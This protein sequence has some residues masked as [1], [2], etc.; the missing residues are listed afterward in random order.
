MFLRAGSHPERTTLPWDSCSIPPLS[1]SH[2][3][4]DDDHP[5]V[6]RT[7]GVVTAGR[8]QVKFVYAISESPGIDRDGGGPEGLRAVRTSIVPK[9][10]SGVGR[11]GVK[12]RV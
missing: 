9:Y 11:N 7:Q 1:V 5:G 6:C 2:C 10:G 12:I 3:E 4:G 8:S